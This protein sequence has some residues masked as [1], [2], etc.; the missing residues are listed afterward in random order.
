MRVKDVL[1]RW[2]EEL[3]ATHLT[4]AGLQVVERNWRCPSGELDVVAWDGDVLVF[5]E[6]KTRS[7]TAFGDPAEALT[8]PK[9]VRIHRLAAAWI[10]AHAD[11]P[12]VSRR[13]TW[14]FD[15]VAI[16]RRGSDGPLL[17]HDRGA[18]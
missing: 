15:V 16:I 4:A 13:S 1:G 9:L 17:R 7:S 14:R 18:F 10:A 8:K 3:A 2:G 12:R 5:V 11:D 6:V